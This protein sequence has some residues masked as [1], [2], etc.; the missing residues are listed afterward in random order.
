MLK[1]QLDP[2]NRKYIIKWK[3]YFLCMMAQTKSPLHKRTAN[4]CGSYKKFNYQSHMHFVWTIQQKFSYLIQTTKWRMGKSWWPGWWISLRTSGSTAVVL[5]QVKT[6]VYQ[7]STNINIEIENL[8]F[9]ACKHFTNY[10]T[11]TNNIY[12]QQV[13]TE[14]LTMSNYAVAAEQRKWSGRHMTYKQDT[15]YI[16][17]WTSTSIFEVLVHT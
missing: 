13:F 17:V 10:G 12:Q 5:T 6:Q 3:P 15:I 16:Y 8:T 1:F 14:K 7:C 2:N 11:N 9:F 4:F